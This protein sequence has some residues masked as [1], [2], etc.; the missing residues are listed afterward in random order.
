MIPTDVNIIE[1]QNNEMIERLENL[2]A[3]KYGLTDTFDAHQQ[4]LDKFADKM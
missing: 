2:L 1:Q 3:L 4:L